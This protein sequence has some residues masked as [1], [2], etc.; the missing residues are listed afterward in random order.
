MEFQS[1]L[2]VVQEINMVTKEVL[3][4]TNLV[5]S[6]T[7]ASFAILLNIKSMIVLIRM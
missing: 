6:F 1:K 3:R 5:L 7:N 4:E 2:V